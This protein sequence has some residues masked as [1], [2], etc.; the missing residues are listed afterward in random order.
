MTIRIR[1]KCLVRVFEAADQKDILFAPDDAGAEEVIDNFNRS[2]S[3]RF[4]VAIPGSEAL[5]LR[6]VDDCRGIFIRAESDFELQIN[7]SATWL[8][9]RRGDTKTGRKVRVFLEAVLTSVNIRP[10]SGATVALEGVWCAFGD[11][12][13]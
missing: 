5:S 12:A 11:P 2:V 4:A 10:I 6:D 1:H 8:V 9:C 7:N 3:G 13:A